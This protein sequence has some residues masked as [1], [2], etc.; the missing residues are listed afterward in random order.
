MYGVLYHFFT[1][2][3]E[4]SIR[5]KDH[6]GLIDFCEAVDAIRHMGGSTRIDLALLNLKKNM[7]TKENGGRKGVKKV[8][9][10]V[11]DGVQT[12]TVR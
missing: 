2:G 11:T 9:V 6:P 4:H 1:I 10:L 8:V 12:G 7:F 5:L 3:A